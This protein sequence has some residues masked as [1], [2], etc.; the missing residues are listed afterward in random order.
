MRAW[1]LLR[2]LHPGRCRWGDSAP[3]DA[4]ATGAAGAKAEQPGVDGT[5]DLPVDTT[6]VLDTSGS[7]GLVEGQATRLDNIRSP[8]ADVMTGVGSRGGFVGLWNYSSPLSAG[9]TRPYRDNV[10]ISERNRGDQAVGVLNQLSFGGSTHTYES[11]SAAYQSAIAAARSSGAE[12]RR[13]R[14]VLI[15]DGPNDGGR[16]SAADAISE[17]K[18]LYADVPV[19]LQVIAIGQNVDTGDLQQLAAAGGGEVFRAADSLSIKEPL[20]AATR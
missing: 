19:Q 14:V 8:L 5:T 4:P 11:L 12:E 13:Y 10:D 16:L 20:A 2:I 3:T 1:W 17:I 6:F 9:V 7:M 15:T 18:R